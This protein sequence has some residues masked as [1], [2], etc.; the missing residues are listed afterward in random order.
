[1]KGSMETMHAT[2]GDAAGRTLSAEPFPDRTIQPGR[3]PEPGSLDTCDLSVVIPLY[4]EAG[5]VVTLC[6]RLDAVLSSLRLSSEVI[7]VDDGSED[8]TS[9]E[10]RRLRERY[11]YVRAIRFR[12]NFGQTAALAAGFEHAR[13]TVVVTLDGDLQNPPEEIPKLLSKLEEGYDLVSGWRV[14]RK[15]AWLVRIIP[16]RIANRLIGWI[17]GT[18]LHDFGCSLK[19][20]RREILDGIQTHGV[21]G[22]MHRFLP[23][24][25]AAVGARIAEIPVAHSPRQG[26]QSKYGLL[27]TAIVLV[28]M[29]SIRFILPYSFKPLK[30]FGLLGVFLFT[31]GAA[32]DLYLAFIKIFAGAPLASRPLLLLG[33]L[34]VMMG[35]QLVVL[36]ILA[37]LQTRALINGERRTYALLERIGFEDG[38]RDAAPPS[39]ERPAGRDLVSPDLK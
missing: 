22:D 10:I 39:G 17:T 3:P 8:G 32:I 25:A 14:N 29:I 31:V 9:G 1:V 30:I 27:R 36:G 28:D 11:P 16:S 2:R 34:L 6:E 20:Y 37:E 18:K 4:N 15:D 12:R 24:F 38:E 23:A 7:L 35:V 33:V 5:N 26:G 19:A 21:H 13:G